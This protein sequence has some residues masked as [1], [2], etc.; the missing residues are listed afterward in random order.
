MDVIISLIILGAILFVFYKYSWTF[1]VFVIG[2]IIL[3]NMQM[4]SNP[5]FAQDVTSLKYQ[6][7]GTKDKKLLL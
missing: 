1:V 4:D 7:L 2:L 5:E 3:Y 6:F